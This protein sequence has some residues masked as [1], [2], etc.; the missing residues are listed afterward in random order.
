MYMY[1]QC[2]NVL[3][4]SPNPARVD[5]NGLGTKHKRMAEWK[6]E[7]LRQLRLRNQ[8]ESGGFSELITS[9]KL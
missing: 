6:L 8:R 2:G 3:R 7:I 1:V 9:C 5:R 4:P